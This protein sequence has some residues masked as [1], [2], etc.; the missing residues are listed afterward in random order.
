MTDSTHCAALHTACAAPQ[1]GGNM[2]NGHTNI[3]YSAYKDYQNLTMNDFSESKQWIWD[4]T[5]KHFKRTHER[6]TDR[7][8]CEFTKIYISH[9]IGEKHCYTSY[10]IVDPCSNIRNDREKRLYV[11]KEHQI[12]ILESA[13]NEIFDALKFI[14]G[15]AGSD[16]TE[17]WLKEQSAAISARTDGLVKGN[18]ANRTD[19]WVQA[20]DEWLQ[21][22]AAVKSPA[23][24]TQKA[25]RDSGSQWPEQI[26][27]MAKQEL[28]EIEREYQDRSKQDCIDRLTCAFGCPIRTS[29]LVTHPCSGKWRGTSDLFLRLYSD[30]ALFLGNG[31]TRQI[32]AAKMQTELLQN[33]LQHYNKERV[34]VLKRTALKLLLQREAADNQVAAAKGLLTY[35]LLTVEFVDANHEAA[36]EWLGWYHVMLEVGGVIRAH[37]ESGLNYAIASA[38][39]DMA[40]QPKRN[41]FPAGGLDEKDV[42]YVFGNVGFSS[43]SKLYTQPVSADVIAR[44]KQVL[45]TRIEREAIQEKAFW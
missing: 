44:A 4:F 23:V 3:A 15:D 21:K 38:T 7:E 1:K 9:Y 29:T 39:A 11:D 20:Y 5:K 37:M 41:Y 31:P 40:Y 28:Q 13:K 6:I 22:D 8:L 25:V 19:K 30:V 32:K 34:R 14:F 36:P 2:E 45:K 16:V 27:A 10:Q 17:E 42:D 12:V 35:R 43:K 18:L 24:K 26:A 33:A